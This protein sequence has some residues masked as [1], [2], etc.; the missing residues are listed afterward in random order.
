MQFPDTEIIYCPTSERIEQLEIIALEL[1]N[2]GDFY[3]SVSDLIK[4]GDFG[5]YRVEAFRW[6]KQKMGISPRRGTNEK[7]FIEV[8]IVSQMVWNCFDGKSISLLRPYSSHDASSWAEYVH[9]IVRLIENI[10]SEY[11]PT[12]VVFASY[13]ARDGCIP[14]SQPD[15]QPDQQP[16]EMTM[17][18]THPAIVTR[19]F[20]FGVESS[21]VGDDEIF[22]KIAELETQ[23]EALN[24]TK[25]KPKKLQAKI[26]SIMEDIKKLVE[27]V[28]G[29]E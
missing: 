14:N 28:D 15:P 8:S 27:F 9:G 21:S 13:L 4:N 1:Q 6:V 20:I 18:I 10:K 5:D 17:T 24:K 11:I 25:N 29:R 23:A 12:S 16:K 2:E 22:D 19:T 7:E 26:D 3:R